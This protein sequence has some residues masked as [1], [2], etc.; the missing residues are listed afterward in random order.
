MKTIKTHSPEG[1]KNFSRANVKAKR[2]EDA[3]KEARLKIL[4]RKSS[5]TWRRVRK[6]VLDPSNIEQMDEI[7]RENERYRE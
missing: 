5:K 7:R 3:A 1:V 6:T 2:L 4:E